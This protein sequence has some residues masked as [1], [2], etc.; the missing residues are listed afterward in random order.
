MFLEKLDLEIKVKQEQ[1]DKLNQEEKENE[2]SAGLLQ[3]QA[4]AIYRQTDDLRLKR[5]NLEVEIQSLLVAQKV[6]SSYD[7]SALQDNPSEESPP[8]EDT[9]EDPKAPEGE[10][11]PIP[12]M[13]NLDKKKKPIGIY[14]TRNIYRWFYPDA[15]NYWNKN[16]L[17]R[18]TDGVVYESIIATG[19]VWTPDSYPE[20]WKAIGQF[21][22]ISEKR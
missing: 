14:D 10:Y 11:L 17:V 18:Y 9:P 16:E 22:Q 21:D 7:L 12:D 4:N 5:R 19:N 6:L 13:G 3:E 20:G 15:N 1:I 2:E 8:A